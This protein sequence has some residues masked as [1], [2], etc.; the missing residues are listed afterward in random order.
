M[1][2]AAEE[3]D[4]AFVLN[5]FDTLAG[6]RDDFAA[7]RFWSADCSQHSATSRRAETVSPTWPESNSGLPLIRNTFPTQA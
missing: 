6:R 1:G 4:R 3:R 7:Q 2:T 5:A